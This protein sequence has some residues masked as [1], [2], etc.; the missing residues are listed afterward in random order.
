M[1]RGIPR[2]AFVELNAIEELVAANPEGISRPALEA[3]FLAARG[4]A[5]PWR[6]LLRRLHRLGAEGRVGTRGEG[7][8]TVYVPGPAFVP[9]AP[10]P[11]EGYVP[12]TREGAQVRALIRRPLSERKPVGYRPAFLEKYRPG[13]TWYLP[14]ELRER[15]HQ[16][17]RTPDAER[18]AG[19][20]AREIFSRLLG[21]EPPRPELLRAWAHGHAVPAADAA[22][23][24]ERALSLLLGLH[25]GA[26]H[27]YGLRPSEFAAWRARFTPPGA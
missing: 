11:E 19:T 16:I 21:G 13:K 23:F 3:V 5:L 1:P 18:P 22:A 2:S 9:E 15:L 20:Y 24:A 14:R 10:P 25:D 8:R 17:G 12:M 4:Y 27:R 26:L 7:R 6:T